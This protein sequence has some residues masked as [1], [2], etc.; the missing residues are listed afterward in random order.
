M[1]VP[2]H[3]WC[4][5]CKQSVPPGADSCPSC[6]QSLPDAKKVVKCPRCGK[7]LLK[8]SG[9]CGQCG[10]PL[11]SPL[12]QPA[13]PAP[14]T[15]QPP[16]PVPDAPPPVDIPEGYESEMSEEDRRAALETLAQLETLSAQDP[17]T[18]QNA[19]Q[20]KSS[21]HRSGR[22]VILLIALAA[23]GVGVYLGF[24]RGR[25]SDVPP[26][27]EPPTECAE[28]EHQ[29]KEATC[30]EPKTCTVCGK[31]EGEALGH[32]YVNNV[33][34]ECGA[35]K[36]PFYFSDPECERQKDAVIFWGNVKNYSGTGVQKLQLKLDLLDSEK[37]L[38]ATE[39]A[40]A[41]VD[42]ALPML[43]TLRWEIRYNDSGIEWKYWRIS[44]TDYTPVP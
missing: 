19:K 18:R 38:V 36:K 35:F 3:T 14:P 11:N 20:K 17:H 9:R 22:V 29:W 25:P 37:N 43:G 44:A 41:A 32:H 24:F 40:Y 16:A 31:T 4:W 23:I 2:M 7:F 39:V 27:P 28:G 12:S 34:T 15:Q 42:E 8:S 1:P 5:Y 21:G 13:S 30:T 6:G 33:C 10:T 26:E